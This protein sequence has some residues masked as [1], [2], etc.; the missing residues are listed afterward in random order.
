MKITVLSDIHGDLTNL[1][2]AKDILKS[3]D[4]TIVSGDLTKR[5]DLNELREVVSSLTDYTNKLLVIPGNMD[6][7]NAVTVLEELDVSVHNKQITIDNVGFT[8]F[9][10]STP[11]PFGT[12]F[13][14]SEKEIVQNIENNFNGLLKQNPKKTVVVCHNPPYNT[15]VDK[16]L[17][18]AHVGSKE[19]R[20]FIEKNAPNVFLSGHIHEAVG[21]DKIGETILLNPGP[22]RRGTVGRITIT[23]TDKIEAK[24]EK[25]G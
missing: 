3:S 4:I 12:P 14:L 24:V 19:I 15:K 17:L 11:T 7:K 1:N 18:G 2:N 9:G 6:G 8:G 5:G 13:E 16:V 22:F 10:G 21:V 20:K 23:K 25:V